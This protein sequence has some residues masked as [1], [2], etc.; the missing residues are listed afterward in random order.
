[1][2][3]KKIASVVISLAVATTGGVGAQAANNGSEPSEVTEA[4]AVETPVAETDNDEAAVEA[5]KVVTD[6]TKDATAETNEE[7][8]KEP[9]EVVT[10]ET[11]K[12]ETSEETKKETTKDEAKSDETKD[13]VKPEDNKDETEKGLLGEIVYKG[14]H[15]NYKSDLSVLD[16]LGTPD[17]YLEDL[18]N[19]DFIESFKGSNLY[20]YGYGEDN[21][22]YL[23]YAEK[24]GKKEIYDYEIQGDGAEMANGIKIGDSVAKVKSVCGTPSEEEFIDGDLGCY[25][26]TKECNVHYYFEN[27]KLF[28]IWVTNNDVV[29]RYYSEVF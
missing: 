4:Q 28:L 29:G 22:L 14:V 16:E 20:Y 11:T 3:K 9:K 26:R 6:E 15:Y 19:P 5:E 18:D 24:N 21:D 2:F 12:D 27:D 1:M 10:E 13:E 25:Y 23:T 8:T 17:F 7:S